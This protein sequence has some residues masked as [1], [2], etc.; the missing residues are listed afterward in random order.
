MAYDGDGNLI[1]EIINGTT[2][3]YMIRSS[4]LGTVLTKLTGTGGKD[5]TYVPTNGFPRVFCKCC[6]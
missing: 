3:D 2:A 5:T 1:G 4:V 6:V